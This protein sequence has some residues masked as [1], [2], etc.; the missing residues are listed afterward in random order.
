[1]TRRE[2]REVVAHLRHPAGDGRT[3]CGKPSS[4]IRGCTACAERRAALARVHVQSSRRPA[5][6]FCGI[7]ILPG[8]AVRVSAEGAGD[9]REIWPAYLAA[10]QA[11]LL[12]GS[13]R[14]G[15]DFCPGCCDNLIRH[16]EAVRRRTARI[17]NGPAA[18][19]VVLPSLPVA[20][21]VAGGTRRGSLPKA[22]PPALV[23]ADEDEP[24]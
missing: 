12:I 23:A 10:D 24:L 20:R 18:R 16:D 5:E 8:P 6:A 15:L 13:E 9:R 1:M 7:Q 4:R 19:P 17:V 14:H 11:R 3:L 2:P 22:L 21:V